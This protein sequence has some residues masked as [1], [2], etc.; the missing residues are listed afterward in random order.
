MLV[1]ELKPAVGTWPMSLYPRTCYLNTGEEGTPWAPLTHY[2]W[3]NGSWFTFS[4][5]KIAFC[6]SLLHFPWPLSSHVFL[7]KQLSFQRSSPSKHWDLSKRSCLAIALTSIPNTTAF[8]PLY[9]PQ[10][11]SCYWVFEVKFLRRTELHP[12]KNINIMLLSCFAM[13]YHVTIMDP[14]RG[15]PPVRLKYPSSLQM[16]SRSLLFSFCS[17][18]SPAFPCPL[19]YR[20]IATPVAKH[21]SNISFPLASSQWCSF[22]GAECWHMQK[23]NIKVRTVMNNNRLVSEP[24]RPGSSRE[25]DPHDP[26]IWPIDLAPG[27]FSKP[28]HAQNWVLLLNITRCAGYPVKSVVQTRR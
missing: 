24:T 4:T 11:I 18:F 10:H 25:V 5:L 9:K 6:P 20:I 23:V 13:S 22:S 12:G 8:G 14:F 17:S 2:V 28:N 1:G 27:E 15:K 21:H 3:E 19:Y 16:T 7:L 26:L